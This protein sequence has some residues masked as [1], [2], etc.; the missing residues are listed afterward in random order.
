MI[1]GVCVRVCVTLYGPTPQNHFETGSFN[2]LIV[3]CLQTVRERGGGQSCERG[4]QPFFFFLGGGVK[5][6]K[7]VL[8]EAFFIVPLFAVFRFCCQSLFSPIPFPRIPLFCCPHSELPTPPN[9]DPLHSSTYVYT[10]TIYKQSL[11][12][13]FPLILEGG[14][15]STKF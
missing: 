6:K 3:N 8:K 14:G 5:D 13:D 9:K 1:C 12:V 15:G 4:T 11:L 10:S 2:P 7:G